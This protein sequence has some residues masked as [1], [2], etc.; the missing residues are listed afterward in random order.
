[1]NSRRSTPAHHVVTSALSFEVCFLL[2]NPS[3]LFFVRHSKTQCIFLNLNHKCHKNILVPVCFL[4]LPKNAPFLNVRRFFIETTV[5]FHEK[6]LVNMSWEK[7][8]DFKVGGTFGE[9]QHFDI[10]FDVFLK[11]TD[12]CHVFQNRS[13]SLSFCHFS[14]EKSPEVKFTSHRHVVSSPFQNKTELGSLH[15]RFFLAHLALVL[16]ISCMTCNAW[17]EASGCIENWSFAACILAFHP[18]FLF[19]FIGAVCDRL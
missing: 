9:T 5:L 2:E 14:N 11:E 7:C 12:F 4:C 3:R 10:L 17:P 13:K 19:F 15:R 1:M 8:N 16:D 6:T 18:E